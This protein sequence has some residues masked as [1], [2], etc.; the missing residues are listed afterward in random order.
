MRVSIDGLE[1]FT[2]GKSVIVQVPARTLFQVETLGNAPV[3]RFEVTHAGEIPVYAAEETPAPV[4][5]YDYVRIAYSA[6]TPTLNPDQITINFD[7]D[8]V[9]GKRPAG[10]FLKAGSLIRGMSI[11][12]PPADD[13]GHWHVETNEFYFIMEGKLTYQLEGQELFT[14]EQGDVV[15][16]PRG[17]FH[18]NNFTG[19]GMATR[20]A[21]FPTGDM[22]NLDPDNPS[23]QA[24]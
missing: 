10:R 23:R 18:R 12:T 11:P 4:P 5:G 8:V 24:P 17:R 7:R 1:P 9:G 14:A 22:N 19:G 3:L 6:P 16:V 20:L 15:Y 21:I 13:Q 2:A